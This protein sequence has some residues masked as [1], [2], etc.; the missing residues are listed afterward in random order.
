VAGI[1]ER[2][3]Y[4]NSSGQIFLTRAVQYNPQIHEVA[5]CLDLV[6]GLGDRSQFK[7]RIYIDEELSSRIDNLMREGGIRYDF[8]AVA[9]GSVWPTKRYPEFAKLIDLIYDRLDMPVIILGGPSDRA[10]IDMILG[11][12]AHPPLD[13]CGRTDLRQSAAVISK[14]R[15]VFCNDSAPAHIAAAVGT[16]VVAIFGPTVRAFGFAPYS[17]NSIVVENNNLDCRPCS[18]HGSRKCPRGHFKCM[19]D[20]TPERI[21]E[22]GRSLL[23]GR[24]QDRLH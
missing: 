3:G 2:I 7:P 13:L 19:K 17:E 10:Q 24:F 16:P 9:P 14:A 6:P 15:I 18:R 4:R 22:A 21:L 5:R 12:V 11:S 20:V 1:P 23:S 8:A